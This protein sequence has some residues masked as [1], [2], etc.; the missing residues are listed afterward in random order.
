MDRERSKDS[1]REY[2]DRKAR[3]RSPNKRTSNGSNTN[4]AMASTE[5]A[6]AE[7]PSSDHSDSAEDGMMED[8]IPDIP[9]SFIEEGNIDYIPKAKVTVSG[10]GD[11]SCSI[12]E[13]NRIRAMLGLRPL[14]IDKDRIEKEKKDEEA[15]KA[16]EVFEKEMRINEYREVIDK[17]RNKR[18]LHAQKVGVS[19]SDPPEKEMSAAEWVEHNRKITEERNKKKKKKNWL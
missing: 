14:D 13:T 8:A 7:S 18:L 1:G 3:S 6:M 4:N 2:K 5:I 12:D 11:L 10:N 19:L 17:S 15:R 16:R 9:V